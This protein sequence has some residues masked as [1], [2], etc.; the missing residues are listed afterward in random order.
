[1]P[2]SSSVLTCC[3]SGQ[4][5]LLLHHISPSRRGHTSPGVKQELRFIASSTWAG[6]KWH[7]ERKLAQAQGKIWILNPSG[8]CFVQAGQ[9]RRTNPFPT[10]CVLH[11]PIPSKQHSFTDP[12]KACCSP[13]TLLLRLLL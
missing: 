13:N 5:T 12:C 7:D 3:G 1:M 8:S 6:C 11:S 9:V 10:R 2:A 4:P